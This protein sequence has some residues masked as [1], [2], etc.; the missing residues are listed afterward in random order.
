M[1]PKVKNTVTNPNGSIDVFFVNEDL[2]PINI[3]P[4]QENNSGADASYMVKAD[5]ITLDLIMHHAVKKC[6][7]IL[8]KWIVPDSGISD[9]DCLTELL[10]VLDDQSLVKYMRTI[11]ANLKDKDGKPLSI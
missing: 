11:E 7:T 3:I 10:G 2:S 6:Q 9:K 4:N 1:I 5:E 8:A